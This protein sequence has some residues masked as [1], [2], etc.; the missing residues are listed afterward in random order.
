[1]LISIEYKKM[2][3]KVEVKPHHIAEAKAG[4][5]QR[6]PYSCPIARALKEQQILFHG[7]TQEGIDFINP[8]MVDGFNDGFAT[9]PIEAVT[10]IQDFDEGRKVKPFSFEVEIPQQ[11]LS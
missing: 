4:C 2:K 7:V 8:N 9:L 10:F 6:N 1:M 5:G 3:T 11:Y